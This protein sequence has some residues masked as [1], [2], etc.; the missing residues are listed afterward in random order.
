MR[1]PW[2]AYVESA[3]RSE[4]TR[5]PAANH[6]RIS[7]PCA[8]RSARKRNVSEIGSTSRS[9]A[10]FTAS[11]RHVCVG[12]VVRATEIPADSSPSATFPATVVFPEPSIPSRVANSPPTRRDSRARIRLVACARQRFYG[13]RRSRAASRESHVRHDASA[14]L[15]A[16]AGDGRHGVVVPAVRRPSVRA[17]RGPSSRVLFRLLRPV[18]GP[19]GVLLNREEVPPLRVARPLVRLQ[20]LLDPLLGPSLR[21][22]RLH[23]GAVDSVPELE[24][25]FHAGLR[26]RPFL[27]RR[28][29]LLGL[30]AEGEHPRF[31]FVQERRLRLPL[32]RERRADRD[33][34]S[35]AP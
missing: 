33:V 19:P 29:R 35:P 3:Y 18:R 1:A 4:R 6:A 8:S 16:R 23:V 14:G 11:P 7:R 26:G 27:L 13:P 9:I 34:A 21:A 12:S 24:L 20:V 32:P 10:H 2:K 17:S 31:E 15:S 5:V 25:P 22:E 30:P 28:P